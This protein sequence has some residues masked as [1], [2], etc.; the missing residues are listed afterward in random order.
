MPD[1]LVGRCQ[2]VRDGSQRCRLVLVQCRNLLRF[3]LQL[4]RIKTPADPAVSAPS[5]HLEPRAQS[6][7]SRGANTVR[8]GR[9]VGWPDL[10]AVPRQLGFMSQAG[11][12]NM[13]YRRTDRLESRRRVSWTPNLVEHALEPLLEKCFVLLGLGN[14]PPDPICKHDAYARNH[15]QKERRAWDRNTEDQSEHRSN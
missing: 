1:H 12:P 9:S 13:R 4:D 7:T 14:S 3:Y 8:L 6:V 15:E 2:T 11:T 10:R 5:I